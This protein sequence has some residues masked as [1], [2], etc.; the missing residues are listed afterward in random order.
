M[1]T[2]PH[3]PQGL[4]P[5]FWPAPSLRVIA[6]CQSVG[7]TLRARVQL[8]CAR[9]FTDGFKRRCLGPGNVSPGLFLIGRLY[10]VLFGFG[11]F[12]LT[13]RHTFIHTRSSH[14][15]PI[16][17]AGAAKFEATILSLCGS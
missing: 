1:P 8:S 13:N 15:P 4:G 6:C 14:H 11:M 5:L 10:M 12:T 7:L 17:T 9:R 2:R 3:A 16:A